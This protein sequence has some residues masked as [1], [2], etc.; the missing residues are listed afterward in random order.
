MSV[1]IKIKKISTTLFKS[2]ITMMIIQIVM[3]PYLMRSDLD[4]NMQQIKQ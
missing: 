2:H 3:K 4:V 1:K